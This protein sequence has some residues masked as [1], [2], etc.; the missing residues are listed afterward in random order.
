M[1]SPFSFALCFLHKNGIDNVVQISHGILYL[2]LFYNKNLFWQR[3]IL[4]RFSTKQQCGISK[5]IATRGGRYSGFSI[6]IFYRPPLV[7]S[8]TLPKLTREFISALNR[9]F[10]GCAPRG[11]G[12]GQGTKHSGVTW[13]RGEDFPLLDFLFGRQNKLK[14]K[15]QN[16]RRMQIQLYLKKE[17]RHSKTFST[18]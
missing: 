18:I 12:S 9:G 3:G 7:L 16:G 15:K 2:S 14:V 11:R 17:F 5:G 6:L 13:K 1:K 8:A 10:R 4:Y